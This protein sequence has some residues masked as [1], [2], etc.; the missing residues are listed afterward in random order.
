VVAR[1]GLDRDRLGRADRL[2]QL[3]RDAALFAVWIAAQRMLAAETRAERSLLVGIVERH[4]RLEHVLEGEQEAADQLGEQEGAR[5]AIER[6]H[7]AFSP[8][9]SEPSR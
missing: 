3:A 6:G 8:M 4:L 5:G 2:A 7:G 9:V 1:L